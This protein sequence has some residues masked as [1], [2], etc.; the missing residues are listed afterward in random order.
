MISDLRGFTRASMNMEAE[1]VFDMLNDYLA[2]ESEAVFKHDG[3]I[4]K[5]LGDGI[6]AVFGAPSL[7]PPGIRKRVVGDGW[8]D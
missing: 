1:D 5:F 4:D 3:T 7:I 2:A 6:L 8:I